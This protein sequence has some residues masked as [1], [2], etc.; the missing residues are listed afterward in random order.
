MT[1]VRAFSPFEDPEQAER[2]LRAAL[3]SE[4]ETERLLAEGIGLLNRALH[5]QAVAA[6]DHLGQALA[7]ERAAAVRLGYGSGEQTAAGDYTAA[8][9]VDARAA[10]A[11]RRRRRE[12]GLRPQERVATVLGGRERLDAC[13]NLVLRA[14]ADLEADRPRE[15]ALQLRVGLEAL[16]AELRGAV[17]DPDHEADMASLAARREEASEAASAALGG[18]LTAAQDHSVRE[19]VA[20]CERVLRRRRVLRG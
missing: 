16:L 14:R 20:L 4:Q 17:A 12:E 2:W 13:E 18:E 6:A 11:S 3:A 10:G 5:A 15:A 9:E 1:A 8:L 19:L 7:P